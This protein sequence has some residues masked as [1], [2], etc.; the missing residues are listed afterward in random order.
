VHKQSLTEFEVQGHTDNVGGAQFDLGLSPN[1][2]ESVKTYLVKEDGISA[3]RLTT[4]GLGL[5]LPVAD[6]STPQ[7]RARIDGLSFG[8][9]GR[10]SNLGGRNTL[11]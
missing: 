1:R 11:P 6:N 4:K 3:G 5:T 2:A 8:R 9:F 7:G 10:L